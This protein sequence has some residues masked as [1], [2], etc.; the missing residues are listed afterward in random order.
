MTLH[1]P[2]AH[3]F[4][5]DGQPLDV[6]LGRITHLGIGAHPDD[7]EFMA[8]HGIAICYDS[9]TE[10]FAGV[11]CT[12]GAGSART[13]PYAA[14]TGEQMHTKRRQEQDN[15]AAIGRY[16]AMIQLAY[17]SGGVKGAE[18]VSLKNDIQEILGA[19]R[20][21][22]VYTHNLADKH[23]THI[24][25]AIAALQAMRALP[26]EERPRR[27][28]GCEVWRGLDW[29][30][31]EDKVIHDVSARETLAQALGAAFDSQISGGK[32]YDLAVLGRHRANATFLDPHKPDQAVMVSFAMDLT[33]LVAD[34]SVDIVE[35]VANFIA[36]FEADV[37]GKLSRQLGVST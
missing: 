24:S 31:D 11:T 7:L 16:G 27:V 25:V 17:P 2:D 18:A 23:E 3:I 9:A 29:M 35:Y 22:I 28:F 36:K 13:G 30:L 21:Q 14:F 37:R 4:V 5:P 12:D 20:P 33:P 10:W 8:Y 1:N 26:A 32:R 6:A 15:A 19:T 34:P